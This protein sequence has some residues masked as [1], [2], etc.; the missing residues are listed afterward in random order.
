MQKETPVYYEWT[1]DSYEPILYKQWQND[2]QIIPN[3][4]N[5]CIKWLKIS[6]YYRLFISIN[7]SLS[8]AIFYE[9]RCLHAEINTSV[10]WTN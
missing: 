3:G 10:L 6:I 1:K 9:N 7:G 8:P 5:Q 2:S 4:L